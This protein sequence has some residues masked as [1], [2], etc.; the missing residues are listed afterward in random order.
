MNQNLLIRL[1]KSL[2][3]QLSCILFDIC[4]SNQELTPKSYDCLIRLLKKYLVNKFSF[5][6]L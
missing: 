3:L 4:I 6:Q 5:I 2:I 1:K